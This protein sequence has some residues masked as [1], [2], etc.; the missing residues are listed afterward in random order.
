MKNFLMFLFLSLFLTATA[1][2]DISFE[3][4]VSV[5]EEA[6]NSAL[7][8]DE[9]LKKAYREAFLKVCER[10]TIPQNVNKLNDLTDDQLSHFI[11]EVSVVAEKS[12][13]TTYMADLNI[14][15][16]KELLKQYML[17]NQMLEVV[18]APAEILIIPTY[19]DSEYVGKYLWED[20]NVWRTYWLEK[21]L[22]KAGNL[23]LSVI[24]DSVSNTA[25]LT[26]ENALDM[27]RDIYEKLLYFNGVKNIFTVHAVRSGRNSLALLIKSADG[28]EKRTVIFEQNGEPFEQAVT[29][30]VAYITQYLSDKNEDINA[31]EHKIYAVY[32][33][34]TL[35][36]W[37][38]LEKRLNTV[39]QIKSV[40][41]GAQNMGK[42]QIF[43]EFSGSFN[44]LA[45]AL[46]TENITLTLSNGTYIL[47]QRAQ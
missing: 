20:G 31:T 8:K 16:N 47:E 42:V 30:T 46:E 37:L 11:E 10:L 19:S 4:G 25:F 5:N 9:G 7:A 6:E 22:I 43:I 40:E 12:S 3:A 17:E 32:R 1:Q 14:K 24:E 15:I 2:A 23:T 29:Q 26:P 34:N 45:S 18:S 13:A 27:P 21:G 36:E 38:E 41:T 28:A 39:A 35:K 33:Y 44:Q